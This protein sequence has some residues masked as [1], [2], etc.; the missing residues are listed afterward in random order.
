MATLGKPLAAF[1]HCEKP[2]RF[3]APFPLCV[4]PARRWLL[5]CPV[6]KNWAGD[7]AER[8]LAPS[9]VSVPFPRRTKRLHLGT[10]P[11]SV[12]FL[13]INDNFPLAISQPKQEFS[14]NPVGA[15]I[16]AAIGREAAPEGVSPIVVQS[17]VTAD[18]FL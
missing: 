18:R 12:F 1:S 4:P 7:L 5:I 10:T 8:R 9:A 14:D 17:R 11:N 13:A 2:H 6:R 3:Q 16:P 15:V